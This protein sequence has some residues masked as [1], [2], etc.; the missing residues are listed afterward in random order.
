VLVLCSLSPI[1]ARGAPSA[2][3]VSQIED[4]TLD[5]DQNEEFEVFRQD[6]RK[7]LVESVGWVKYGVYIPLVVA[8]IVAIVLFITPKEIFT[9]RPFDKNRDRKQP[10]ET[11]ESTGYKDSDFNW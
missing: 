9:I 10:V 4:R 8:L 7:R 2:P 3:D 1:V 6:Q 5:K 11:P